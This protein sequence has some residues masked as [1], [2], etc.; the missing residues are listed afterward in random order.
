M[1]DVTVKIFTISQRLSTKQNNFTLIEL[2]LPQ[3]ICEAGKFWSLET[4]SCEDC[5]EGQ[6]SEGGQVVTCT[7]CPDGRTVSAGQGTSIQSCRWSK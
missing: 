2:L 4:T 6:Y 5:P 1:S 3:A 7:Q